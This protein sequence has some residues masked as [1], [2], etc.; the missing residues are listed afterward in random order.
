[1]NSKRS[2]SQKEMPLRFAQPDYYRLLQDE[3]AALHLHPFDIK[4]SVAINGEQDMTIYLRY[5][6][7]FHQ[8]KSF[9]FSFDPVNRMSGELAAFFHEAAEDCR[10]M[11]IGDFYKR[12]NLNFESP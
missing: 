5:G 10:K 9:S 3:M 1:M 6:E 4:S 8:T 12:I 7:D 2:D 11:M